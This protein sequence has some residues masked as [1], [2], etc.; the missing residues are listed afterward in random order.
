MDSPM[1]SPEH[2]IEVYN[3]NADNEVGRYEDA[4]EIFL[5]AFERAPIGRRLAYN[6]TDVCIKAGN[7]SEAE[8]YYE[9]F[10]GLAPT[11]SGRFELQYKMA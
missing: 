10:I 4:K 8:H 7:F 1:F 2:S 5:M 6:L 3:L 9:N 11:D